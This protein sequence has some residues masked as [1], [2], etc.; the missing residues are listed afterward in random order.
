[1]MISDDTAADPQTKARAGQI[2]GSDERLEDL[3]PKFDGYALSAVSDGDPQSP[4]FKVVCGDS[5]ANADPHRSA[6]FQRIE[7]VADQH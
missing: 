2:L 4:H 5:F 1:M 7:A 6:R 3:R